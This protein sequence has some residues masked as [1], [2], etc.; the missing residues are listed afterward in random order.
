MRHLPDFTRRSSLSSIR[1]RGILAVCVAIL[2]A[3]ALVVAHRGGVF[4]APDALV[5][6]CAHD[7][8]FSEQVLRDFTRQTGIPVVPRYDTEA[9]KSLGLVHLLLQEQEHPRCDVFWNNQVLGT[10]DLHERGLLLPYQG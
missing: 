6:Y 3:L 5:V 10:M 2:P 8:E 7:A 4:S 1:A 9:T